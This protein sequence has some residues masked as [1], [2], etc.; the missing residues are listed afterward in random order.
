MHQ[1]DVALQRQLEELR[2]KVRA[3][4]A[5]PE[6]VELPK[7]VVRLGRKTDDGRVVPVG[8]TAAGPAE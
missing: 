7:G 6:S 1:G 3:Y 4:E 8:T 5:P 2:E